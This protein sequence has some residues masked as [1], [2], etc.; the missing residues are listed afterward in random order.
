MSGRVR[1]KITIHIE[2]T[3]RDLATF[4]F[5]SRV[6]SVHRLITPDLL[7]SVFGTEMVSSK[8]IF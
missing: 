3:I 5:V 4:V 1:L 6:N 2:D 8:E 7:L